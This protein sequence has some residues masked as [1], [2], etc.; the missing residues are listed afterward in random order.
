M[1]YLKKNFNEVMKK[2]KKLILLL[3]SFIF[4]IG[5]SSDV[6]EAAQSTTTQINENSISAATTYPISYDLNL[7]GDLGSNNGIQYHVTNVLINASASGYKS[8]T[9]T[10]PQEYMP[11][12]TKPASW[13]EHISG[14]TI[15][16]IISS[17]GTMGTVAYIKE[18]LENSFI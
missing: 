17:P 18:F 12:Y 5:V 16:F 6:L 7:V 10:L 4:L 3:M 11:H 8:L 2:L 13:A 14:N 9:I 15:N 1:S